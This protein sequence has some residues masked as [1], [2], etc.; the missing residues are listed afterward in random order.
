MLALEVF[1]EV[2]AAVEGLRAAFTGQVHLSQAENA[3]GWQAIEE[4]RLNWLHGLC[5][6]A[7]AFLVG[8]SWIRQS[9]VTALMASDRR[10]RSSFGSC[11]AN[12]KSAVRARRRASLSGLAVPARTPSARSWP[13]CYRAGG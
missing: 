8:G 2:A 7:N 11:I 4:N 12:V 10:A 6:F 13:T 9:A 3:L 1:L 5:A